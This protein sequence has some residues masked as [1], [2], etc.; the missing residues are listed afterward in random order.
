[1]SKTIIDEQLGAEVARLQNVAAIDSVG[2]SLN[3]LTAVLLNG[4]DEFRNAYREYPA[5]TAASPEDTSLD[6]DAVKHSS[7][8]TNG[9]PDKALSRRR[10]RNRKKRIVNRK[11]PKPRFGLPEGFKRR[12]QPYGRTVLLEDDV[13]SFPGGQEFIPKY[14]TGTLGKGH[15]YALLTFEQFEDGRRGSVYVHTDGRIF[16]YSVDHMHLSRDMFDT[17]YTICDLERTGRYAPNDDS[18]KRDKTRL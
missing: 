3:H 1:M 4:S 7:A 9:R 17:G 5:H 2:A 14:P 12:S 8:E 10:L 15:L 16:D 11:K 13:Y 18:R 6:I